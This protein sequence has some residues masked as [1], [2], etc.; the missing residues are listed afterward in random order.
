MG[1][2]DQF[3]NTEGLPNTI[4]LKKIKSERKPNP[5]NCEICESEF[6]K[7]L[8][9]NPPRH[10]KRCAKAVCKI[11]SDNKKQLSKE[12][13]TKYRVCDECDTI[14]ENYELQYEH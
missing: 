12:D 7:I 13:N 10:C 1:G 14:L 2:V 6:K 3:T 4:D 11:C 9:K 8:N 5:K